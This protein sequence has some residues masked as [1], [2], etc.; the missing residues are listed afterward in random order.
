MTSG[1][2]LLPRRLAL[3]TSGIQ[4]AIVLL[5]GDVLR[6]S[7]LWIRI[8]GESPRTL[9]RLRSLLGSLGWGL[10]QLE[11]VAAARGPGSFTGIRV[12]L[13]IAV[14]L[15][16]GRRIP[17]YVIDSLPVLV[18]QAPPGRSAVAALRDAGR[19]EV[20]AWREGVQPAR[21]PAAEVASW[22]R[23]GESIVVE[24]AGALGRWAESLAALE[25]PRRERRPYADALAD[26][27]RRV[28]MQEKP[29]RYHE[30]E[31]LY[32]QPAAAEEQ[33]GD[34]QSRQGTPP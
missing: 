5:E 28:F 4:Q 17:L 21:I 29:V 7:E 6:A 16:Y 27:A 1:L 11:A 13:S 30:L 18:A 3:D 25:I 10:D 20:F 14:G 22:V 24:P 12:G 26:E 9:A 33:R 34:V 2:A 31:A 15:A 23:D 19:G 32:V 8:A